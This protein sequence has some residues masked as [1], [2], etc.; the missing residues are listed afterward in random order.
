MKTLI[1]AAENKQRGRQFGMPDLS[2]SKEVSVWLAAKKSYESGF[3]PLLYLRFL[4]FALGLISP[5]QWEKCH[6]VTPT[7][8]YPTVTVNVTTSYAQLLHST[9]CFV[10]KRSV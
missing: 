6:S 1:L 8:M 5:T 4:D 10:L 9:L 7:K 2:E 3:N